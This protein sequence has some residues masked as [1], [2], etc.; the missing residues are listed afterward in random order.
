MHQVAQIAFL[1]LMNVNDDLLERFIRDQALVCVRRDALDARRLMVLAHNPGISY[2]AGVLSGTSMQ[3]PTAAIAVFEIDVED[4]LD[5]RESTSM[6]L[7]EFMRPKA[8]KKPPTK[9]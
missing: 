8:L 1:F 6:R 9:P 3:M 5:L 2:A 4:W 7:I